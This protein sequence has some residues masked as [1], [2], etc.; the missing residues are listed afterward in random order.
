MEYVRELAQLT[1]EGEKLA[2]SAAERRLAQVVTL[3]VRT[4]EGFLQNPA[5]RSSLYRSIGLPPAVSH[6]CTS[7]HGRGASKLLR[8]QLVAC[9]ARPH[10][11]CGRRTR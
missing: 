1:G 7:R 9:L 5:Q 2:G 8:A 11:A 3:A 6:R 10:G 4:P